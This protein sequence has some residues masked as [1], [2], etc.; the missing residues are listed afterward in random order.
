MALDRVF[1]GPACVT[2][3]D[4][5]DALVLS[6]QELGYADWT[7]DWGP[8][9]R[10]DGCV[11]STIDTVGKRIIFIMA[12]RPEVKLA[13]TRVAE[14]LL[15]RCLGIGEATALITFVL[16]DLGETNW[17]L[18]T[19]G[20]IGGPLDRLDEVVGHVQAGCTVYSGTGWT[21]DGTRLYFIAGPTTKWAH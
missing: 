3:G 14:D 13:L 10:A 21:E 20:P 4:A 1:A 19:D 11:S 5:G 17:E 6:L 8:G 9:V 12:L 16:T 2:A 18:R 15:D 7:V